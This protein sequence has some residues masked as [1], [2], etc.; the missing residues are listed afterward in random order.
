MQHFWLIKIYY[1]Q[2]VNTSG[3]RDRY[4]Y[5]CDVM[6]LKGW[7]RDNIKKC[8]HQNEQLDDI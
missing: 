2:N 7:F 6:R 3:E 4:T 5:L 8:Q 1:D